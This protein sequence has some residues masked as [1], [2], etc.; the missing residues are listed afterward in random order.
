MKKLRTTDLKHGLQVHVKTLEGEPVESISIREFDTN[1]GIVFTGVTGGGSP[2]TFSSKPSKRP[3][4]YDYQS[5]LFYVDE[6]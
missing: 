5:H 1:G 2:F 6:D 3:L 4:Q